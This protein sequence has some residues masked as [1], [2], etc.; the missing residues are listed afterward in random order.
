M[1]RLFGAGKPKAPAP[2]LGD[3]IGN[4]RKRCGLCGSAMIA[5]E[6]DENVDQK[7]VV[8]SSWPQRLARRSRAP[9]RWRRK[10]ASWTR[11]S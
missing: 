8:V 4:V 10:S 3:V 6:M 1:N 7:F 5:T 2:T 9:N 11:S